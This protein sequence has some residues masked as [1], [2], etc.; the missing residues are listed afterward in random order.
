MSHGASLI[1]ADILGMDQSPQNAAVIRN[2]FASQNPAINAF[3]VKTKFGATMLYEHSEAQKDSYAIPSTFFS[4]PSLSMV[5]PLGFLGALSVGLDEKFF[6][7]NRLELTDEGMLY[8][9]RTGIYELVPSYSIRLPYFLNNFAIG[10]SYRIIFGN[11]NSSLERQSSDPSYMTKGVT[12]ETK[13]YGHFEADDDWWRN[14]GAGLHFHSKAT[15]YFFSYFPAVQIQKNTKESVQY[16]NSNELGATEKTENFKLPSRFASGVHFRFLRNQNLSFAYELQDFEDTEL[17]AET[18]KAVSYLAE[19]KITG[20]GLYYSSFFS[21]N[22]FGAN[23]WYAEKYLKDVNEFGASL[24]SD[25]WLG[26]R[27][28]SLGIA[29]FGGYRTAKA[30]YWDE[31]FFGIK[32]NLTGVGNWGTSA[33]RK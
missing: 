30:P 17:A 8:S 13:E 9:A 16:S 11:F 4:V 32:F 24:L 5:L 2:G 7:S 33:R 19:Y 1:G 18:Q 15:D 28:T 22:N 14:F 23:V 10:A 20:T 29:L 21:R 3:E 12:I 27:G 31:T 26:Y 25:L 6:A